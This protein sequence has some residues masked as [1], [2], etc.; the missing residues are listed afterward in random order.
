MLGSRF[1]MGTITQSSGCMDWQ[2]M[3]W[4]GLKGNRRCGSR[5]LLLLLTQLLL[6]GVQVVEQDATNRV[7]HPCNPSVQQHHIMNMVAHIAQ[8]GI[9]GQILPF[10]G[11]GKK[12]PKEGKSRKR[13]KD[14]L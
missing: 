2:D 4:G 14:S 3:S 11:K 9:G 6:V 13:K 8:Q 7:Y 12:T 1:L 10:L 5:Q